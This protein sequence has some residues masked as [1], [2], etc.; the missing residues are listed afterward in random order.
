MLSAIARPKW[1]SLLLLSCGLLSLATACL[2]YLNVKLISPDDAHF[3]R[4]VQHL[5]QAKF[6]QAVREFSDDLVIHPNDAPALTGRAHA[7]YQLR[8]YKHALADY[9]LSLAIEPNNGAVYGYRAWCHQKLGNTAASLR[10][11]CK[12]SQL[13][14]LNPDV[15][16]ANNAAISAI[17]PDKL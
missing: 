17:A 7:Y 10:D 15:V 9:D 6:S 12:C 14:K 8:D 11:F 16:K 5:S 2:A 3:E 1:P 4:A 13:L